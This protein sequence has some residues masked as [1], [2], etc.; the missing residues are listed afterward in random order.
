MK[1]D[2]LKNW[3]GVLMKIN[4]VHVDGQT[5]ILASDENVPALKELI[6]TSLRSTGSAFVD[7]RTVGRGLIS[8]LIT[9]SLPVRFEIL[10]RTEQQMAKW[11]SDPPVIND[12][13]SIDIDRFLEE[14]GN[15]DA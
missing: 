6:L 8:V 11:E 5:F 12:E 9:P 7:F 13:H 3:F 14:Y 1:A 4:Q 2:G 15:Y 10:D